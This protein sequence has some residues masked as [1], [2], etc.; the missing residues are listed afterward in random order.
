MEILNL[1]K[2]NVS[3]YLL[4]CLSL[5]LSFRSSAQSVI[6]DK[7]ILCD[8]EST[9]ISLDGYSGNIKNIIWQDS[10]LFNTWSTIN[11]GAYY[12]DVT[13]DTMLLNSMKNSLH[14]VSYRCIIDT[15]GSFLYDDT[16]GI[17][18]ITV[19]SPL[20]AGVISD[21]DTVC[22]NSPANLISNI[23]QPS[24]GD[25]NYT[26]QWSISTDGILWSDIS[27]ATN[28]SFQSLSLT[29]KTYYR[30]KYSSGSGCGSVFS[31]TIKIEVLLDIN[32]A[33]ISDDQ[34]ICYG[35]NSSI[36]SIDVLPL[37]GSNLTNQW[38]ASID[39][40]LWSD[41][42]G[43]TSNSI[44]PGVLSN[45]SYFRLKTISDFSCDPV[46]SNSVFLKMY[47]DLTSGVIGLTQDLCYME[48]P[49]VLT[50]NTNATGADG[51]YSY[52]WQSSTDNLNWSNIIGEKG[53]QYQP[54]KLT[55]TIFYRVDVT[56][57]FGCG[58]LIT[59]TVSINVFDSLISGVIGDVDT[60]CYNE[61]PKIINTVISPIGGDGNYSYQWNRSSDG[62]NWFAI[63]GAT[64]SSYQESLLTSTMLY[65]L[66]YIS[67]HNCGLVQSNIIEVFVLKPMVAS[68]VSDNQ[69]ICYQTIADTLLI[70][71]MPTG[72]GDVNYVN[73]WQESSGG[74]SWTDLLGE[75]KDFYEPGNLSISTY[76]RV[77]SISNYSCGPVY[78]NSIFIEVFEPL[79]SGVIKNDTV[80]CYNTA[81]SIIDF[82]T[83]STGA[84]NDYSYQWYTSVDSLS[85]TAI[86]GANKSFYQ[87][88]TLI[89]TAYYRL[90]TISNEGCGI[91]V[92]NVIKVDVYQD[93][94]VGSIELFDTICY[95]SIPSLIIDVVEPSGGD[96]N[97]FYNWYKSENGST[98]SIIPGASSKLFQPGLLIDTT[99]FKSV[100]T[101]GSGCGTGET[102]SKEI[103]VFPSVVPANAIGGQSICDNT[104]PDTLSRSSSASG[105]GNDGFAYQWQV[106][107][108]DLIWTNIF[109]ETD[110]LYI[111]NPLT[112]SKFF[113]LK[114][115]SNFGCGPKYSSSEFV[116]VYDLFQ[117]G[118]IGSN[119]LICYNTIPNKF[120]FNINASGAN[121]DYS[122]QWLKSS[123]SLLWTELNG[124]IS[125]DFIDVALVDTAYYKV[126]VTSNYGCGIDT[127]G[128]L[129][130]NVY[131]DFTPGSIED[132]EVICYS[133]SAD[134]INLVNN[135][136]GGGDV[137]SYQWYQVN[138]LGIDSLLVGAEN[139]YFEP[140][141]LYIST[142]YY[143]Q[144]SSDY[145]CG[146]LT[147]NNS[148]VHVNNLPDSNYI[149]GADTLCHLESGVLY[150]SSL[151]NSAYNYNW[152]CSGCT[153]QSPSDSTEIY[154]YWS[155]NSGNQTIS[156]SQEV[157]STGC[158]NIISKDLY[159]R[160]NSSPGLADILKKPGTDLLVCSD[161]TAGIIYE[162]GFYD[163]VNELTQWISNSNN[164]FV[165]LPHAFDTTKYLYFVQT[166]FDDQ[167]GLGCSTV[168]YF[169]GSPYWQVAIPEI[170]SNFINVYPNPFVN[171]ISIS[172]SQYV[173]YIE[174]IDV[175][176][177]KIIQLQ[178]RSESKTFNIKIDSD[179]SNGVY[180]VVIYSK[181]GEKIV[182][183]I[184]K[185]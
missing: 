40:L 181:S 144:V 113:R 185:C 133:D 19:Y 67:G 116:E 156:F 37:G 35:G 44:S 3:M 101:S 126:K 160:S 15:S 77:K 1:K 4:F 65:R 12:S 30:L 20:L 68:I 76:Y 17:T 164:Q 110:S 130:V 162:W 25:G 149:L 74:V 53:T 109:G 171:T 119:Q 118:E 43:E 174:L 151:V 57:D 84:N 127:T 136:S 36:I 175:F 29:S 153:E 88:G 123:D 163:K 180:F 179:L 90:S 72:G 86:S 26:Y 33:V 107:S 135:P 81:P 50:F 106:S 141:D 155:G 139:S 115:V 66:D 87:E 49:S 94:K 64:N 22:Y 161:S 38:Q 80:I 51:D 157:D 165:Q 129:S 18:T 97:Y 170:N 159:V 143:L 112:S 105:G 184:I 145:G 134:Q 10:S 100:Q 122:Y 117:P 98:W 9:F 104:I 131:E 108:D 132:L 138:P 34:F 150:Q 79:I 93:F 146:I 48:T 172:T 21:L 31:N 95:G 73:Q 142:Q 78:S 89:D 55:D 46:F 158:M 75:N 7:S 85:W 70:D 103:I 140:N 58:A 11:N 96:G 27:G 39:G 102:N 23:V 178:V 5:L 82:H 91:D 62:L 99:Y 14:G 168:S 71:V 59:N 167:I 148:L 92:S 176:G 16:V 111:S 61:T 6:L 32:P 56:S 147:T 182:K 114:T 124:A 177:N 54:P 121:G 83:N 24:G 52:Q 152:D 28:T 8:E 45:S 69:S 47:D 41:I 63:N 154:T 128:F 42:N 137:Y 169:N 183:K 173:N 120:S 125:N 2:E 60:I 13:N 166:S